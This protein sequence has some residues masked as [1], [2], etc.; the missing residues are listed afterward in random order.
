MIKKVLNT[1]PLTDPINDL[2]DEEIV[3]EFYENELE[4]TNQKYLGANEKF[5]LDFSNYATK[6]DLKNAPG[7]DSSVFA[8]KINLSSGLKSLKRGVSSLRSK[9]DKL[10][11]AILKTVPF[12]LRKL[13]N[14]VENVVVEKIG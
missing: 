9:I 5:V 10:D 13:S 3:G 12:D 6:T 4:K 1:L 11:I 8:K 2:N 14:V 7:V